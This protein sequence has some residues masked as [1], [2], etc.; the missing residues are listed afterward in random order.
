MIGKKKT[1]SMSIN[2]IDVNTDTIKK[3]KKDWSVLVQNVDG[4]NRWIKITPELA[5]VPTFKS[6]TSTV[7]IFR[8]TLVFLPSSYDLGLPFDWIH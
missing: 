3:A 6:F 4:R 8:K 1:V 2:Y 5:T 7:A